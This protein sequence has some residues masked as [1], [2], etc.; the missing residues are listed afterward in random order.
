MFLLTFHFVKYVT[1]IQVHVNDFL[2]YNFTSQK[3]L[4]AILLMSVTEERDH[5]KV[6]ILKIVFYYDK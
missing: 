2:F 6:K 5:L 3:Y 1:K 4:C